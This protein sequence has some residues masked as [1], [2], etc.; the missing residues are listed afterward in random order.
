MANDGQA[1]VN[2][3]Q[4][5]PLAEEVFRI[6][7][8]G[9]DLRWAQEAWEHVTAAGLANYSTT[10]DRVVVDIRLMTIG[11][12]YRDWCAVAHD[13]RQD[14]EPTYWLDGTDIS[15]VH[16]GQ[17]IGSEDDLG[18]EDQAENAIH[19]L[20]LRERPRI[21]KTLLAG[22]GDVPGLFVSLWRSALEDES[23]SIFDDE[24]GRD[25][26]ASDW[27]VL[28]DVTDEKL[29]AYQWIDQG[30]ERLGPVRCHAD[31]D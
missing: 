15:L 18:D 28:N 25:P 23:D 26:T 22:F 14:D 30:C 11:S 8:D 1:V 31:S 4:L 13:E 5:R 19:A 16:L 21:L 24:D 17:L 10:L 9:G 29:A 12:I 20:I 3:D 7:T 2:W 6:W 27:E